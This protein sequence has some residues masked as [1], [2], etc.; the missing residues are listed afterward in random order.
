[1]TVTGE[2]QGVPPKFPGYDAVIRWFEQVC[3]SD[4]GP[5]TWN[6]VE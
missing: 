2:R 3:G 6:V 4:D 1:M 5:S